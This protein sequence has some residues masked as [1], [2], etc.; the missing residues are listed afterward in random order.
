VDG[1]NIRGLAAFPAAREEEYIQRRHYR[2]VPRYTWPRRTAVEVE[3]MVRD[4][5]ARANNLHGAV[6]GK[7]VLAEEPPDIDVRNNF[8]VD[9]EDMDQ[10]IRESTELIYEGCAVNCLQTSIILMNMC[11]L[12][13][14]SHTFM[15]EL[16]I[17]LGGDLLPRSNLLPHST[18]QMKRM[19]MK[20]GLQHKAIHCY[21]IG[22]ILYE[23]ADNEDLVECPT[24]A[25]PRYIEGSNNMPVK[26][27]RYFPIIPRFQRM[28]RCPEI[29]KLLKWH[30]ANHSPNGIMRSVV[31]S[32]QW[33][34]VKDIDPN[35]VNDDR[36][37]YL[38]LVGDGV[39]PYG[40]Q[41]VRHSS[42]PLLVV[43]YNLPP[44][45]ATRKFFYL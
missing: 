29:A 4:A 5:F 12:Y 10:L 1:T 40:N 28:F 27:L 34:S 2:E 11:S 41:S 31:D 35:F 21:P 6:H 45:L 3:D 25:A 8:E 43:I 26:V 36:N 33:A 38:G 15:D 7:G 30:A 19:I 20:M 24:C 16:L 17:F 14:V 13:G 39:N 22:H 37:L 42:W 32:E 9:E 44:W 23:G 18:Y